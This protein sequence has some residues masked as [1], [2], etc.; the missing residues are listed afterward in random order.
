MEIEITVSI[1]ST[2]DAIGHIRPNAG[3]G[4]RVEV[5]TGYACHL[6]FPPADA[7]VEHIADRRVRMGEESILS[8]AGSDRSW[9]L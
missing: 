9:F 6:K 8:W 5:E 2:A 3:A 1:A 7:V 4:F